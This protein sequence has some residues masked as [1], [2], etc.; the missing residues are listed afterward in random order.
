MI[1]DG[2][3]LGQIRPILPQKKIFLGKWLTLFLGIYCV[4]LCHKTSKRSSESKPWDIRLYNFSPNWAQIVFFPKGN[5]FFVNWLTLLWSNYCTPSY[6]ISKF[7]E[8]ES[9]DI[10]ACNIRLHIL[11]QIGSEF[12]KYAE[13]GFL[14]KT[15]QC[16]LCQSIVS[17]HVKKFLKKSLWQIIVYN[18]E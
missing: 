8:S 12:Q 3:I 16:Y 9:W 7:L 6:Y 5:F 15:D 10:I 4:P 14:E 11:A 1:S 13:R 2:V 17:H 18:V